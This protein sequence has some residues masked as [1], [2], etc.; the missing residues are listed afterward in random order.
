MVTKISRKT[1]SGNRKRRKLRASDAATLSS[2]PLLLHISTTTSAD[3][4]GPAAV[5]VPLFDMNGT[6]RVAAAV[7]AAV[8]GMSSKD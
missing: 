3:T 8:V 5:I 6:W 4:G 2:L 7:A 1:E